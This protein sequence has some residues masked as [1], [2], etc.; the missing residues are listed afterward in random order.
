MA[1]INCRHNQVVSLGGGRDQQ[2]QI[3][4]TLARFLERRTHTA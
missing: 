3:G 4:N 1:H 2:V